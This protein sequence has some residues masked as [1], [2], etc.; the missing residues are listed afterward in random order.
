MT[1]LSG[2]GDVRH[3]SDVTNAI[4]DVVLEVMGISSNENLVRPLRVSL[5]RLG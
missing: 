2:E 4:S 3:S 1:T 5:A